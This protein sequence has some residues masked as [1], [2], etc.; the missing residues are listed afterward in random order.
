MDA[1]TG[2]Y[3]NG[4]RIAP[5]GPVSPRIANG[6][7]T[8]LQVQS[9]AGPYSSQGAALVQSIRRVPAPGQAFVGGD[10]AQLVDI[11][12]ALR[13]RTPYALGVVALSTALLLFLFTGGVLLPLKALVLNTLSLSATFGALVYVFQEGHL[14]RLLGNFV[15]T[16]QIDFDLPVLMFCVAFGL[17]MDY[18]VFMLARIKEE[19]DRTGDNIAAAA[20]G[21]QATGGLVTAAALLFAVVMAAFATSGLTPLKVLGTG[22]ALA[23]LMDATL[24]RGVLVPAFMRLAGHAN[25]WAPRP[26]ARLH[27]FIGLTG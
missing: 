5:A 11:K 13:D 14:R 24:V 22:M 21:L 4:R 27:R 23:V 6:D 10:A 8:W 19:Y 15:V 3:R 2:T 1:A 12:T 20:R 18:E 26:L 7:G 25:W 9:A 17:S 16:G